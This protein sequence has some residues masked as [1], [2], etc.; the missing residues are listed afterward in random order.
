MALPCI[1]PI[2]EVTKCKFLNLGSNIKKHVMSFLQ[3]W[4]ECES[5]FSIVEFFTFQILNIVD[6]QIETKMI[7][8]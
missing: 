2:N 6:S 7:F 5:M 8:S 3:W 4:E 1:K